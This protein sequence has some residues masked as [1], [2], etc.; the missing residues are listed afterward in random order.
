MKVIDVSKYNGVINWAKAARNCDGAIIRVGYRGYGSGKLV[1]DD[2]YKKNIEGA[3]AAGLPIGVYFVTQAVTEAE[4]KIEAQYTMDLVKGYKL[5]FPIFI[6]S[7][8]G[9]G[10]KGR[11]DR[12]KLSKLNRTAILKAFCQE[13][14][15]GGYKAGVYASQSW[16]KGYTDVNI[17]RKYYLWVAKYSTIKPN[18]PFNAW[19]YSDKGKIN[20][21]T[22]NVDLSDFSAIKQAVKSI[23]ELALEV[24]DGKWGNGADRKK[25]LE[26]A[27]Y[28]YRKVQDQVNKILKIK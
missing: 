9:N 10:G 4:A 15:K 3:I 20:G 19:Q 11:A 21:I 6:D 26:A 2:R 27:G 14:E 16:L 5:T 24:L 1:A 18:I 22:G 25:N 23:E 7:E 12:G 28:D 8:D 13:V 17:L